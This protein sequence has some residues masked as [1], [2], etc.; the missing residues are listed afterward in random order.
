MHRHVALDATGRVLGRV[1][2]VAVSD[3]CAYAVVEH[4]VYV[5]PGA[6]GRGIGAALLRELIE[7][8][9]ATGI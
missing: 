3:R 5:H 8:T 9:E 7:S 1:A 6:H 2:A 4:S